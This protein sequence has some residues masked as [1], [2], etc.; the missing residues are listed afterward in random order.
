MPNWAEQVT[1]IATA[2]SAIGLLSAI[3][4]VI[5]AGQQAREA[6]IGRQAEV[7]VEFF[8]RWD[9]DPLVETRRLVAQFETKEALRDAMVRFI[10]DNAVEAYVLYRELDYFEQLGALEQH[11]GFDFD[12]IK[13]LLGRRLVDRWEMWQPSIDAIGGRMVYPLFDGLVTKMRAVL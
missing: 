11:G 9:E 2:V 12:L 5:F 7:A 4:A 8:R 3:G 13:T 6:R 10:A 1:A